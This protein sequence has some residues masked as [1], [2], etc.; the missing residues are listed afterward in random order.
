MLS[1]QKTLCYPIVRYFYFPGNFLLRPVNFKSY[2]IYVGCCL[3][4]GSYFGKEQM[5]F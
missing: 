1:D 5:I 2:W 3:L 4:L